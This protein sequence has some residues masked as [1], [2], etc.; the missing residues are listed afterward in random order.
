MRALAHCQQKG[1][2]P[3]HE[4]H[5]QQ[6]NVTTA[7]RMIMTF[8]A[9]VVLIAIRALDIR[10]VHIDHCLDINL[11][12]TPVVWRGRVFKPGLNISAHNHA[13]SDVLFAVLQ[14]HA[15]QMVD[16]CSIEH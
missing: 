4:A 5:G 8:T 11:E 10:R 7:V 15:V 1:Q 2:A 16:D 6:R 9:V 13:L 3:K 12:G 14:L